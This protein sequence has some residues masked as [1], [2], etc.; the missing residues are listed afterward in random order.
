[1]SKQILRQSF[2]HGVR[3]DSLEPSVSYPVEK[4]R[5]SETG[6]WVQFTQPALAP[7][8]L[9]VGN[10]S[11]PWLKVGSPP[12]HT[13]RLWRPGGAGVASAAVF[14]RLPQADIHLGLDILLEL[15]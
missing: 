2:G 13:A 4:G 6:G 10:S 5:G 3:M 9:E 12:M 1:M 11:P 7:N 14:P 8:V 15:Q